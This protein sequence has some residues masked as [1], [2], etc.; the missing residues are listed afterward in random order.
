MAAADRSPAKSVVDAALC[1]DPTRFDFYQAVRRLECAHRQLP[2]IG[3]SRRPGDDPVR[4]GQRPSMAFAPAMLSGAEPGPDGRPL[5]L[6]VQFLGLFGPNGPLPAHMTDYAFGRWQHHHDPTLHRFI[7]VFHHRAISLFYRAWASARPEV[8]HDRPNDDR[9]ATYVA[10]LAGL[11]QPEAGAAPS[12]TAGLHFAGHLAMQTRHPDGLCAILRSLLNVNVA[13]Q[14]FVG[15][16]LHL[17]DDCHCRLGESPA[18]GRLGDG[19]VL[20]RRVWD[21]QHAFRLVLGPMRLAS[22]QRL[23]PGSGALRRV[24][25]W[26]RHYL[27]DALDYDIQFIVRGDELPTARLDGGSQ[28]GWNTWLGSTGPPRDRDD[29]ILRPDAASRR[30]Q[31]A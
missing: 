3:T 8:H 5:Q 13:I 10:S 25:A 15:R 30:T 23:L 20:G 31:H 2:R 22:Y 26:V 6:D 14:E 19:V 29:L 21:C 18:T 24:A 4:F 16:W 17:P 7:N 27:G 12:S 28:L 1:A 9:F 11:D